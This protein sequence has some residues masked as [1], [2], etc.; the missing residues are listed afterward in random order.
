MFAYLSKKISIPNNS[1]IESV[2][3]NADQGWVAVGGEYYTFDDHPLEL[4]RTVF[5]EAC[6]RF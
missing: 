5:V 2:S 3:W 6:L 4:N 1:R